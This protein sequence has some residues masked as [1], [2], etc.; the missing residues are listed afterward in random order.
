MIAAL[1]DLDIGGIVWRRPQTRRLGIVDGLILACNQESPPFQSLLNNLHDAAPC[2][3]TDDGIRL[4]DLIK[5]LL[6]IALPEAA[7][8]NQASTTPRLLIVRHA[9]HRCDG[10]FLR[11]LDEG[12]GVDDQDIRLRRLIG[13]LNPVLLHDAEHDLRINE[14]LCTTETDK[15]CFH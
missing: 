12:A 2:A 13:D 9:E 15:T 11:G 8:H 4:G 14:I 1:G 5:Q 6:S 7:C 10:F 3:C